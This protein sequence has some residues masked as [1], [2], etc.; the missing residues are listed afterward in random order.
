MTGLLSPVALFL[1][2]TTHDYAIWQAGPS[3]LSS[4][5][6]VGRR[7]RYFWRH[8][9]TRRSEPVDVGLIPA[10]DPVGVK[11]RRGRRLTVAERRGDVGDRCSVSEQVRCGGVPQ[12][13]KSM[14][15]QPRG[16][17]KNLPEASQDQRRHLSQA[18]AESGEA[19][20]Q[21]LSAPRDRR[22]AT[23]LRCPRL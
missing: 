15:R 1:P 7:G 8:R 9:E 16:S 17:D 3:I 13:I 10:R 21:P 6:V 14:A 22:L 12:V 19:W 20:A 5:N 18:T 23:D 2:G 4:Q 11:G